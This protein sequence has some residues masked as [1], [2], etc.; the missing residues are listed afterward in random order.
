MY[1]DGGPPGHHGNA[2]IEVCALRSFA[3]AVSRSAFAIRGSRTLIVPESGWRPPRDSSSHGVS[4][5]DILRLGS[6][7]AQ[8][9]RGVSRL[10]NSCAIFATAG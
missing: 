5:S 2:P 7:A 4:S 1:G 3:S 9:S 6:T 10:E 8:V